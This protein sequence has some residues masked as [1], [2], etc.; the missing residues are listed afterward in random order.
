[1]FTQ[2]IHHFISNFDQKK[3]MDQLQSLVSTKEG[4]IGIAT[5]ALVMSGVAVYKS[6]KND[7]GCPQVPSSNFLLGSTPEFREDPV[8]F[9]KKWEAKLGPVY[10]AYLFGQYAT[11]VSGPQVREIFLNEDFNFIE[12]IKRQFDPTL[13]SNGGSFHDLPTEA[14]ASGIKKNLSPKLPFYTSRVIEHFQIGLADLCGGEVP[15]EGKEFY[16]VYPFVQHMV[17]KASASVFVGVELAKNEQ[18]VDSF[19]NM[20]LEVGAELGPKPYLEFFPNIMKLRMWLIGKTSKHVKRHRDQL[21]RALA[22]EVASRLSAMKEND[23]NWDRPNDFLQDILESG[24]CP[25]HLDMVDYCVRWTTEIIFAALHTTSENGTLAFYRLLDNPEVLE[26]LYEEQNQVLEEAG[27]DKSVGPEV[28]TREIL[29]KFVKMDSLI[30]ETSR[31]R[32]DYI[33]LPHKNISNKTITLSSGA[34]IH[35]GENAFLNFY[36]N[37]RDPTLQKGADNV[38][39]FDA[40][41]FVNQDKNSTKIGEDFLFFGMGKHSCP[42]RWFAIQEIKTIL[43]MLIRSYKMSAVGPITFPV[44]CN[45]SI[46]NGQFKIVPRK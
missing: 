25:A 1:M 37:H 21:K 4:V 13:L 18:L 15:A 28:F 45:S 23:S 3:T 35:P 9:I 26:A 11:V 2:Y 41:R 39:T 27:F 43:S 34:V 12:G 31:L 16:H 38:N 22:P 30:R 29:N 7:R 42:G 46:P 10:G 20:V 32:N 19:K 8:A 44:D 40:F 17:A 5:A 14:I 24:N 33:G 6:S 36:S